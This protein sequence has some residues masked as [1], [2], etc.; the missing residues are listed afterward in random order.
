MKSKLEHNLGLLEK[1][2]GLEFLRAFNEFQDR[3]METVILRI[4]FTVDI[5]DDG[6]ISF[7]EF[8]KSN[9]KQVLFQVCEEEDINRIRDYFSYEH[10]YVLYIRFWELDSDHDFLISKEDF[11]KYEGH[12]LSRKVVNRIFEQ[13]PRKF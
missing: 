11:G 1:H 3:Y 13:V 4:F 9:L 8:K 2:P 10:F 6:R 12:A 7:R 5:N